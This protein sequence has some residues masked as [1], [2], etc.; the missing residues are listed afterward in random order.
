MQARGLADAILASAGV[1]AALV[2]MANPRLRRAALNATRW[3]LGGRTV[4]G[5]LAAEA[6]RA[7]AES[8]R[9]IMSR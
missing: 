5:Y 2:I 3:W 9:D 1:A 7:W 4:G 6:G 8:R